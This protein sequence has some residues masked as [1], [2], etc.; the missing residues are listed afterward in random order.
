[1]PGNNE[2]ILELARRLR[3]LVDA[4]VIGG[5]AV[6]LHGVA[7]A[8]VDLDLYARNRAATVAQL[9]AAG[10]TWSRAKR[11][12]VLEG[13]A[14]HTVTAEEALVEIDAPSV[15][16]GVRVVKLKDL[17]AIK[18]LSGLKNAARHK[19]LGDVE[20]L[21]RIVPLDKR[22][23]GKLPKEI[24][25]EFKALVDAVRAGEKDSSGDRRF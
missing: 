11:E 9:E 15:I 7:R 24:R 6:Y 12:H 18:L 8:T 1:M 4:P 2:R 13:V 25:A 17:V 19:D 10:A 22:F 5:I 20:E 3:P 16:D 23:A 21:I 14:I